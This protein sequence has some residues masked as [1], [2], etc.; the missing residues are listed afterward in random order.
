[1]EEAAKKRVGKPSAS[2]KVYFSVEKL[3][4]SLLQQVEKLNNELIQREN[5]M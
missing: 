1:M 4:I 2:L 5:F 3:Q